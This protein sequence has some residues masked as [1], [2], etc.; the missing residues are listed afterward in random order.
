L[1]VLS[2]PT[3]QFLEKLAC[4]PVVSQDL[5]TAYQDLAA[6]RERER[7]ALAWSEGVIGDVNK[8]GVAR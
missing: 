7:E 1:D 4:P 8:P 5:E 2:T 6:A 3:S